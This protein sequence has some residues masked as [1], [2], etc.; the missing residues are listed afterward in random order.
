MSAVKS[1]YFYIIMWRDTVQ[2][3]V[4]NRENLVRARFWSL[5]LFDVTAKFQDNFIKPKMIGI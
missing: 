5:V 1:R 4:T 3:P 2:T